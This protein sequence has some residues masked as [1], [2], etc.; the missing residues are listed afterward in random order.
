MAKPLTSALD[1]IGRHGRGLTLANIATQ[2]GIIVTGGLVRLTSSGLGC[3]TWPQCEP[4]QF[5]PTLHGETAGH[6]AIEFGNRTVTFV[7]LL[8]AGLL[9]IAIWRTRP[10]LK[11]WGIVPVA[12][13]FAQAIV[14]GIT[15]RADLNPWIVGPHMMIS[16]AL[17]WIAV[18]IALRYR[19]APG[20][21][22]QPLRWERAAHAVAFVAVIV[23]GV[24]TTGAGPHSGDA[25]ATERLALDPAHIARFHSMAAWLFML[26]LGLL[27]WRVRRDRS[28]G[29]R[30]EVRKS[31]IVLGAVTLAQGVIGYVQYFTGLPIAVVA[32]HLA[33]IALLAAAESAF[34]FLTKNSVPVA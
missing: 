27:I 9:A 4:G 29:D 17:V 13:V 3:S 28:E 16:V 1:F 21:L 19:H 11:W 5:T 20:R 25:D 18:Y 10:D 24:L 23:L 22:G 33:G 12:G 2:G 26:T 34:W 32:L 30:D 15:V 31:W 14:G 8:V 7:L 6:Q